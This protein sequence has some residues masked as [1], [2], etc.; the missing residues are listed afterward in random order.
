MANSLYKNIFAIAL[1]LLLAVSMVLCMMPQQAFADDDV[2]AANVAVEEATA[3]YEEATKIYNET[4]ARVNENTAK[5]A[6]LADEIEKS[7]DDSMAAVSSIYRYQRSTSILL[8]LLFSTA[9][10][11]D[12]VGTIDYLNR[13]EQHNFENLAIRKAKKQELETLEQQHEAD[14]T[15]ATQAKNEAET[16]LAEANSAREAAIAAAQAMAAAELA[17]AEA[18]Y[19]A[20]IAAG[21]TNNGSSYSGDGSSNSIIE[22]PDDYVTKEAYLANWTAR[23]DAYLAGSPLAGYGYLFA[24][25]AWTYGVD[26]RWA[27]AISCIESSKGAICF[28]PYNAWGWGSSSWNSWEEAIPEDVA[29]LGRGYGYTITYEKACKYCPPNAANW[30]SRCVAEMNSI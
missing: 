17:A 4:E 21:N 6:T 19:Q 16:A 15:I 9:D 28:R 27:P 25:S 1:S 14:M 2:A 13:Y 12:L 26:P 8:D 24:E 11:G 30:Y 29:G 10:I 3:K 7:K 5:I 22:T 20:A 18:T 23:I